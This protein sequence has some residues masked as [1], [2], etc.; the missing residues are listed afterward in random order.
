MSYIVKCILRDILYVSSVND[1]TMD[2]DEFC[3]LSTCSLNFTPN[4]QLD[5]D[6]MR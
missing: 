5:S 1:W 4:M 6:M 3:Q 2:H